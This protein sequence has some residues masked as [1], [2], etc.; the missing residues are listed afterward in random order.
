MGIVHTIALT[1]P[2]TSLIV[3]RLQRRLD[4][5]QT[6]R[7]TVLCSAHNFDAEVLDTASSFIHHAADQE[8]AEE[9]DGRRVAPRHIN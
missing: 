6:A 7:D 5:V 8:E 1:G 4:A 3:N 9:V 2:P